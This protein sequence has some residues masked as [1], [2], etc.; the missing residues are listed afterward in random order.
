VL[1][2]AK[3]FVRPPPEEIERVLADRFPPHG[4]NPEALRNV[5]DRDDG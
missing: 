4:R 3:R 5:A 1:E 2:D